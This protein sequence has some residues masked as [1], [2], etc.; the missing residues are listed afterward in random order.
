MLRARIYVNVDELED[1]QIVNVRSINTRGETKYQ[2]NTLN[3]SFT[4]YHSKADGWAKL[5]IKALEETGNRKLDW[6]LYP[7]DSL[8]SKHNKVLKQLKKDL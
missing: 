7:K 5:L 3:S 4:I 6:L 2:V 8:I 1:I